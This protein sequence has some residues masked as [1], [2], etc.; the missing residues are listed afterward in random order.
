[1]Q[2]DKALAIAT[3]ILEVLRPMCHEAEIC[4]SLRRHKEDVKD[5]EIICRPR[6]EEERNFFGDVVGYHNRV[7][8]VMQN[9]I[10]G[11]AAQALKNGPRYK[12]LYLPRHDINLDLFVVLPPAQWGYLLA[13]RTGPAKYSKKLVTI[14]QHGGYLP[15]NLKAKDGAIWSGKNYI[16]MPTEQSFFD[17]LGIEMPDPWKRGLDLR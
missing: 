13:I 8:E 2:Y 4:G 15:S 7:E 17:V 1:M 5:I 11:G 6:Q 14:R 10:S 12:Q 9:M 3:P 16:E